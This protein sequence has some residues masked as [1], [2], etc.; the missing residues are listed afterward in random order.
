MENK[1]K[2]LVEQGF[3]I[4]DLEEGMIGDMVS[5]SVDW[6]SELENKI[7]GKVKYTT[8]HAMFKIVINKARKTNSGVVKQTAEDWEFIR[9]HIDSIHKLK[10]PI[11][12]EILTGIF[13]E[14]MRTG[15]EILKNLEKLGAHRHL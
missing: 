2:T 5:G 12:E 9:Y 8:T 6:I 14:Y 1:F 11:G 4:E 13:L 10:L 3:T 15:F 7:K